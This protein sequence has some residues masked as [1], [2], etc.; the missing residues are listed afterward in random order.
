MSGTFIYFIISIL[1]A[2]A[3]LSIYTNTAY[4][5]PKCYAGPPILEFFN[6]FSSKTST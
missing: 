1:Y 2:K 5:V 6:P 3:L 4:Y